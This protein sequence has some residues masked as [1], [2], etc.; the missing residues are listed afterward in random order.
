MDSWFAAT[1]NFDFIAIKRRHFIAALKDKMPDHQEETQPVRPLP[2]SAHQRIA[3]S[4]QR[5]A[6]A[7]RC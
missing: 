2:Q 5:T 7:A 6:S 4:L 3:T 1:E